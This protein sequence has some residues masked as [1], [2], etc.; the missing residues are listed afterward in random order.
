MRLIY[1]HAIQSKLFAEILTDMGAEDRLIS[2]F[3]LR[4]VP[5]SYLEHYVTTGRAP[6]AE[7]PSKKPTRAPGTP[8]YE[9]ARRIALIQR[10]AMQEAEGDES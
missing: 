8:M 1:A 10:L 4:D 3:E 9:T 7:K 2:Y 5:D 6:A